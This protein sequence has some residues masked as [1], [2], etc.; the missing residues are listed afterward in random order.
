MVV[1]VNAKLLANLLAKHLAEL[2]TKNVLAKKI[3]K[4]LHIRGPLQIL[5]DFLGNYICEGLFVFL[6]FI[7][8]VIKYN[9]LG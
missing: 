9:I 3:N 8:L 7:F 4:S 5:S 2:Q 6:T 1:V